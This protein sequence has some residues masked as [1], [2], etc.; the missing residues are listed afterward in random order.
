M[1]KSNFYFLFV[2]TLFIACGMSTDNSGLTIEGNISNG[3]NLKIF[4]D[5][6]NITDKSSKIIKD[7]AING[8]G[9]FSMTFEEKPSDGVYR[10]RI[11]TVSSLF[12]LDG[13]ESKIKISGSVQDLSNFT[14][15]VEG[16]PSTELFINTMNELKEQ[17][18]KAEEAVQKVSALENIYVKGVIVQSSFGASPSF[19]GLFE[20]VEKEIN[21]SEVS[22]SFK[23]T[24]KSFM[25]SAKLNA[26]RSQR[27]NIA[28][29]ADAP[30]ITLPDPDGNMVSLSDY[31][32]KLVLLDFWASWCRPCRIANPGVVQVYDKYKDQGFTVFS[33]SLDGLDDRTKA[34]L[35][36]DEKRIQNQ[37]EREK[38][39][40][41]AAIDQDN[42]KWDGHVSDLKKW[43]SS[44]ARLYG[45]SSIPQTYLIDRD[46]K[47]VE[48]NP[49]YNL[50]SAVRKHL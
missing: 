14:Y 22:Q 47:I 39:R 28:I 4:L 10:F 23:D 6:Y 31:K 19:M 45:V 35:G 25:R 30:D 29:G 1:F 8:K 3:E 24:Y 36:G 48:I 50:E 33:V 11:G 20:D 2:L 44:A 49:R 46:G 43:N 34:R 21:Q 13:S 38:N 16:A 26:Q 40:W 9:D 17:N 5:E 15:S 27:G 7:A 42:L 41:I 18:A 32:G 12:I 37:L